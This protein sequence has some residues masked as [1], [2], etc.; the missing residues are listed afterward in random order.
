MKNVSVISTALLLLSALFISQT[1]QAQ[2][3]QN[4]T[5]I[6]PTTLT[7]KVG[8]GLDNPIFQLHVNGKTGIKATS[9]TNLTSGGVVEVLSTDQNFYLNLDGNK[10]QATKTNGLF[11]YTA[12]AL[13]LN[14]F[15]GS[16]GVGTTTPTVAKFVVEGA[17]GNTVALFRKNA[18]SRGLSMVTDWPGLFLNSYYNG[19]SKAMAQGFA[20]VVNFDPD[21]GRIDFGVTGTAAAANATIDL[22]TR[23][24][25]NKDGNVMIGTANDFGYKLAVNGNIRAK[26]IR[27]QTGWADYV[28]ADDY[29]L[30]PLDEVETFIKANKHLPDIQPAKEIQENGLDVAAVTTKMMAKIEELTLYL[31]D[32]KKENEALKA[33]VE[34]LEKP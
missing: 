27:V 2:W 30:R 1:G 25:I 16:V 3:T 4:T 31:I 19:G 23:M 10:L 28:F 21:F 33:R 6:Y 11:L 29:Q 7:K 24:S 8:I 18:T 32:M 22:T 5:S 20:G 13:L 17:V 12:N 15:G 14:P 9:L 34:K 26:E